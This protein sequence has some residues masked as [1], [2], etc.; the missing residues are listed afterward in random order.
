MTVQDIYDAAL[1]IL[2]ESSDPADNSDYAERTPF[3]VAARRHPRTRRFISGFFASLEN[4]NE[5]KSRREGSRATTPPGN[6][7]GRTQSKSDRT[8]RSNAT[9][10]VWN[11]AKSRRKP[12]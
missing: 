2:A 11:L 1:R 9:S 5:R 10:C 3:I 4:D 12:K 6:D 8:G 7:T